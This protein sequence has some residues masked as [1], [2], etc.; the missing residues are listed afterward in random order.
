[1]MSQRLTNGRSD[2]LSDKLQELQE[3]LF[4]TKNTAMN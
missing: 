2:G 4:A 3:L 1:M